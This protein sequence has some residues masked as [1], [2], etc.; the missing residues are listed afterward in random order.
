MSSLILAGEEVEA[1][2]NSRSASSVQLLARSTARYR[3]AHASH[4]AAVPSRELPQRCVSIL[5]MR[6]Q[7]HVYMYDYI[8]HAWL[9]LLQR[10]A[11]DCL[12]FGVAAVRA[13]V[14]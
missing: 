14:C 7:N 12:H 9:Y 6:A 1:S 13:F 4:A 5:Y 11:S 10:C 2:H 3:D 8:S